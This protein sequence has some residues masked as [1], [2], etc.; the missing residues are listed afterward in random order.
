MEQTRVINIK[1]GATKFLPK[2]LAKDVAFMRKMGFKQAEVIKIVDEKPKAAEPKKATR[3][4][5][6]T[7][8][9]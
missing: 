7:T 3:K 8:K 1:T 5:R 6:T 9:N 2:H 4:K